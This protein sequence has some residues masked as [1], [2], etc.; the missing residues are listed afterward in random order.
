ML[1]MSTASYAQ[2]SEYWFP[3]SSGVDVGDRGTIR[4]EKGV[5]VGFVQ[6]DNGTVLES[7]MIDKGQKK[8][9][10]DD[11]NSTLELSAD[12]KKLTE[13]LKL[14]DG[15]MST[16]YSI[17]NGEVLVQTTEYTKAFMEELKSSKGSPLVNDE[18]AIKIADNNKV[19]FL[20]FGYSEDGGWIESG[21]VNDKGILTASYYDYQLMDRIT[22]TADTTSKEDFIN[23]KQTF[24]KYKLIKWL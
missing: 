2:V 24:P 17:E 10:P 19:Y 23:I 3:S 5:I 11:A 15:E 20:R 9:D 13:T 6:Y 22:L 18:G 14:S 1:I 8:V 21:S 12:G 16:I 4:I 7:Y